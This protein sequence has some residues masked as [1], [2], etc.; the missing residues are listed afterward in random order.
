MGDRLKSSRGA[1]SRNEAKGTPLRLCAT[2]TP[3]RN[4]KMQALL[5]RCGRNPDTWIR[6]EFRTF[7]SKMAGNH[8]FAPSK[9]AAVNPFS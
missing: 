3:E 8:A 2:W 9:F 6:R 1:W 7:F 5:R 4:R